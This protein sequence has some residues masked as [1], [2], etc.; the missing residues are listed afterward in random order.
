MSDGSV[1]ALTVRKA[2]SARQEKGQ[3]YCHHMET[4]SLPWANSWLFFLPS[5]FEQTVIALCFFFFLAGDSL[6]QYQSLLYD[7]N[8]PWCA[9]FPEDVTNASYQRFISARAKLQLT[10]STKGTVICLYNPTWTMC[11]GC[12]WWT[13]Y[14]WN[15]LTVDFTKLA[16]IM[17][18]LGLAWFKCFLVVKQNL[19]HPPS[20]PFHWQITCA[21]ISICMVHL[22]SSLST[23]L[24]FRTAV[25]TFTCLKDTS[26]DQW[27]FTYVKVPISH[28][29][30]PALKMILK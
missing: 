29:K 17:I 4:E 1:A 7:A 15:I 13:V 12:F 8:G 30:S 6:V 27:S 22:V 18:V 10:V 11:H 25:N 23:P 5:S 21:V 20:T 28:C 19:K 16:G 9:V 2:G 26:Y 3:E 14:L 24:S